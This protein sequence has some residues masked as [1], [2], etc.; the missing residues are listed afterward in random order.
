[1]S[2]HTEPL[3]TGASR[4]A[5]L[6]VT[7]SR[8]S[9]L[10]SWLAAA[11]A[12]AFTAV[13]LWQAG[14]V[15]YLR[16]PEPIEPPPIES[17]TDTTTYEIKLTGY[18]KDNRPYAIIATK[19]RQDEANRDI[20]YLDQMLAR[21]QNGAGSQYD[22]TTTLGVYNKQDG[23]MDM[24]GDVVVKQG[25]RFT[26]RM[27]QAL[28]FIKTKSLSTTENVTVSF[29]EG[30]ITSKGME[31]TDDGNRIRFFNGVKARFGQKTQEGDKTP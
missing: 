21:F 9:P 17:P 5:Q 3:E 31:I 29:A 11:I 19:G 15:S 16:P 10:F 4:K 7:W 30:T 24:R 27:A 14:V 12:I 26:A 8:L 25:Q 2:S 28:A 6:A 22:I 18:D 23:S 1:M 13:F 20:M